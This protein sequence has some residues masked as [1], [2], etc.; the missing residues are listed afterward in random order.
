MV[1]KRAKC[2][3]L[4]FIDVLELHE[5]CPRPTETVDVLAAGGDQHLVP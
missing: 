5:Q 4:D 2:V 3:N 1:E